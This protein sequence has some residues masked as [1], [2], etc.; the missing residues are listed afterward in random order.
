MD[1]WP[2][3]EECAS[4]LADLL[5]SHIVQVFFEYDSSQPDFPADLFVVHPDL[6][7]LSDVQTKLLNGNYESGQQFCEEVVAIFNTFITFFAGAVSGKG[8]QW[9]GAAEH[10]KTQ[11]IKRARAASS[12]GRREALK[13]AVRHCR[14][15]LDNP[16]GDRFEQT[17]TMEV[18]PR[19]LD[20]LGKVNP[21]RYY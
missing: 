2:E 15:L 17:T 10:L 1:E 16:L 6:P 7:S 11:F 20:M 12:R 4:I 9:S 13:S 5:T 18:R 8:R 21:R 19:N 14:S 3:L